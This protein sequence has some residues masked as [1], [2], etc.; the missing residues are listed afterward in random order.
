MPTMTASVRQMADPYAIL[1]VARSATRA[2]IRAAYRAL[3]DR[4]HPDRHHGNPLE[5]LASQHMAEI[6]QAYDVLSDPAQRADFDRRAGL[7]NIAR[8]SRGR[9]PA[10][11]PSMRS[12]AKWGLA[13][14]L[15]PLLLR[16]GT[17]IL[18]ALS[19]MLRALFGEIG[20]FRGSPVALVLALV[21][22]V[23]LARALWRR[24]RQSRP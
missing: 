13:I 3:V 21:A 6:N 14:L 15:L 10:P 5:D 22:A 19:G 17:G 1:G 20:S 11:A 18:R 8:D 7:G 16:S 24:F 2:E 12:L 4:Y 9:T 23:F